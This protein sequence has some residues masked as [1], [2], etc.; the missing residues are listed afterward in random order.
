MSFVTVRNTMAG[1]RAFL[2]SITTPWRH[3]KQPTSKRKSSIRNPKRP[4]AKRRDLFERSDS[5]ENSLCSNISDNLENLVI[6]TPRLSD[7]QF[8]YNWNIKNFIEK[9]LFNKI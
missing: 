6:V 7:L 8:K 2:Q 5:D 9:V 1:V 3:N 4:R